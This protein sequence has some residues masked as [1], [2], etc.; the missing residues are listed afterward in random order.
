MMEMSIVQRVGKFLGCPFLANDEIHK[1]IEDHKNRKRVRRAL[2][3]NTN[4]VIRDW[5]HGINADTQHNIIKR[6]E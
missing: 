2:I 6:D 1:L 3:D 4:D 5:V